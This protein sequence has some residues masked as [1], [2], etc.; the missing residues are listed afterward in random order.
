MINGNGLFMKVIKS[1]LVIFTITFLML[2]CGSTQTDETISSDLTLNEIPENEIVSGET[3]YRAKENL[4]LRAVGELLERA[5]TAEEFEYLLNNE[6]VNNLDLNGDGYVDYISV[7]EYDDRDDNQRGF[8]L[9]NRF[10]ANEIQEIASIIFSRDQRDAPGARVLLTGNEQ[11]Y[12]DN[13]N[14]ETNWLD[15]S[16]AIADWVFGDRTERYES[17][18]YDDNYPEDYDTYNVVETPVYRTRMTEYYSEPVFIQTY[19]PTVRNVRIKSSYKNRSIKNIYAGLAKP[20]REQIEFIRNNPRRPE[21]IYSRNQNRKV[22]NRNISYKRDDRKRNSDKS[23]KPDKRNSERFERRNQP[24]RIERE[25]VR[26]NGI[27]RTNGRPNR[28]ERENVRPNINIERKDVKSPG[29]NNRAKPE[30]KGNNEK[31]RGGG[32]GNKK[33]GGNDKGKGKRP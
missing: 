15:K 32:R 5:E 30:N 24:N 1:S 14:Y 10:G 11:I 29:R 22:K 19:Q 20:S 25:N 4:D 12:G 31:S 13:Y 7:A 2:A 3:T 27:E 21:V 28:V 16:I 18:Y 17:P 23:A 26:Q 6:G 9:F 8:T 33:G